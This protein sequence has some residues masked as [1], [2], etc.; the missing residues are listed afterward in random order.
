[1][2]FKNVFPSL[3]SAED[4]HCCHSLCCRCLH[5]SHLW[6][7]D[8]IDGSR[9]QIVGTEEH[10]PGGTHHSGKFMWIGLWE[11]RDANAQ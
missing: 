2:L 10:F 6:Y 5:C 7:F 4:L 1:M 11:L 9:A 3:T 8:F